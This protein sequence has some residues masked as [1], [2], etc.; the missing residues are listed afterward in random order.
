[1]RVSFFPGFKRGIVPNGFVVVAEDSII[2]EVS[3]G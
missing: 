1:M 2:V 3:I